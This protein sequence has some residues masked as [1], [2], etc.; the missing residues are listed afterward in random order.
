MP[1]AVTLTNIHNSVRDGLEATLNTLFVDSIKLP[2][3]I[4]SSHL[5]NYIICEPIN[6]DLL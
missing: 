5:P 2:I 3:P 4:A 6:S 1:I